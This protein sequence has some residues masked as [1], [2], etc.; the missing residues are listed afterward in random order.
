LKKYEDDSDR[1][2]QYEQRFALLGE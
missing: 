1:V 2:E